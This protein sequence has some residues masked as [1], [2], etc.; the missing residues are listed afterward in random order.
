MTFR[1]THAPEFERDSVELVCRVTQQAAG[2]LPPLKLKAF[3]FLAR[4]LA[5]GFQIFQYRKY[6]SSTVFLEIPH[7]FQ[8]KAS[9]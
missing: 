2:I 9:F 4:L 7:L 6:F 3:I 5:P 8:A 1:K